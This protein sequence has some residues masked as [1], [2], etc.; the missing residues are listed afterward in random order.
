MK[1]KKRLFVSKKDKVARI[2]PECK[3]SDRLISSFRFG[4][5]KCNRCN[6]FF[7]ISGLHVVEEENA[8]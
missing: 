5:S 4:E 1:T 3:K 8:D 2:C 7:K 6:K